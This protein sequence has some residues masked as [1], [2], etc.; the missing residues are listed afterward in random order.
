MRNNFGI[1]PKND[2]NYMFLKIFIVFCRFSLAVTLFSVG[3]TLM[4]ISGIFLYLSPTLPPIDSLQHVKLQ[5]P[6]KVYTSDGEFIAQFGEKYRSPIRYELVPD[7]FVKAILAAEDDRFFHHRGIDITSL[8]RAAIELTEHG[9]IKSGGS[10]I[11]MQVTKNYLLDSKKTFVR[12]FNE[13]LLSLRIE[14]VLSKQEILE[15]YFNVIYMGNRAYGIEAAAKRYYGKSIDQLD[16]AQLAT[17]AGLP[18]APSTNNPLTNPNAALARRNWI[19]DRMLSLH[20][21]S[22]KMHDDAIQKPIQTT[23]HNESPPVEAAYL[24]EMVRDDVLKKYSEQQYNNGWN[25]HTT[26]DAH[27]QKIANEAVIDGLIEYER[28]HGYRGPTQHYTLSNQENNNSLMAIVNKHVAYDKLLPALITKIN[29]SDI[30]AIT[31]DGNNITITWDALK[32]AIPYTNSDTKGIAPQKP[33]DF[34]KVGDLIYTTKTENE[35]WLLTQI[36]EAEAAL[37]ALNPNDGAIKSLVGGFSFSRSKFNRVTQATRQAGSS[38]KPFIYSAALES[39]FNPAS[40]IDD[41]PIELNNGYGQI[42]K[43]QNSDG[44]FLGPIRLREALYKSRN[45]V[46]VRLLQAISLP[47][48]LNHISLFGFDKAQL[49]N[50]FSLAL[51]TASVTPLSVAI[52]YAAFANG[53]YKISPYFITRIIDADKNIIFNAAPNAVC[54]ACEIDG[55]TLNTVAKVAPRILDQRN[56]YM[57]NNMLSDVVK[58]GT[59]AK[60]KTLGRSDLAGKTG[61]TNDQKDNWF[62]GF[63]SNLVTTVWVGFDNPKSL[64]SKEYGATTALPIWINY[65]GQALAGTAEKT[66]PQPEGLT[67]IKIN[68]ATGLIT[69]SDQTNSIFELFRNEDLAS[70]KNNTTA[71]EIKPIGAEPTDKKNILSPADLF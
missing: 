10:T 68:P 46:S 12:K 65:M 70:L 19:L 41:A 30:V 4:G 1:R 64:G 45:L 39:G 20:Y 22:P 31:G 55:N 5:V 32:W 40:I 58:L 57:M 42:W 69:T 13:I 49:P 59:A 67:M 26:L 29:K 44:E 2:T 50:Q 36:P 7:L 71:S 56:V 38:F 66:M 15:L 6:M 33:S 47:T 24:A 48:A 11:T 8:A 35:R 9:R 37:V 3:V 51:G 16:L 28:R 23:L 53:G 62:A 27:L 52:G 14:Q 60:A 34:L 43:P 18:K 21:I 61:T 17:L 54:I 63:N 25:I